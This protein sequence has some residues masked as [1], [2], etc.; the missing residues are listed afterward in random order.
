[1]KTGVASQNHIKTN[2]EKSQEEI[3][4]S[5]KQHAA[6]STQSSHWHSF[7][8]G[9]CSSDPAQNKLQSLQAILES[10]NDIARM[11]KIDWLHML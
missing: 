4:K 9:E 8:H 1:M 3:S 6:T 2:I 11:A 5:T 7:C 10:D